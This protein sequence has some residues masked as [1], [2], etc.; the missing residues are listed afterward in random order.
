MANVE[1]DGVTEIDTSSGI[2]GPMIEIERLEAPHPASSPSMQSISAVAVVTRPTEEA[3]ATPAA[4]DRFMR[5]LCEIDVIVDSL[6]RGLYVESR[7]VESPRGSWPA[8]RSRGRLGSASGYSNFS[9]HLSGELTGCGAWLHAMIEL[10]RFSRTPRLH[11]AR[12]EWNNRWPSR[13][14]RLRLLVLSGLALVP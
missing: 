9:T 10:G 4:R 14:Q 7:R 1:S 11:A 8:A 13:S 2:E 6:P 5:D 12:R 3:H